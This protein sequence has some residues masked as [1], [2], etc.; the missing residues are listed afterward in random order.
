MNDRIIALAGTPDFNEVKGIETIVNELLSETEKVRQEGEK[1][2]LLKDK[3]IEEIQLRDK[4][5]DKQREDQIAEKMSKATIKCSTDGYIQS[6]T[7][8]NG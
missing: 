6:Y 3:Q 7:K 8:S 2:L 4:Q 1:S 5:L